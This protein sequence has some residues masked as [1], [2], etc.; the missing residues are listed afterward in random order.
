MGIW[1]ILTFNSE[2][3]QMP[4]IFS[5]TFL[6]MFSHPYS[7]L[8]VSECIVST[9]VTLMYMWQ[10]LFMVCD[11]VYVGLC[12]KVFDVGCVKI[13]ERP[14]MGSMKESVAESL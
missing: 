9:V 4:R 3:A 8:K 11:G 13:Y 1:L 7:P 14:V 10:S 6:W 12:G 2:K 5:W